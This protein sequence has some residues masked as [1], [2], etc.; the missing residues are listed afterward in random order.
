[1]VTIPNAATIALL[2][3]QRLAEATAAAAAVV[4]A[5]EPRFVQVVRKDALASLLQR[6]QTLRVK[7]RRARDNASL[8]LSLQG[9]CERILAAA[10]DENGFLDLTDFSFAT[11]FREGLAALWDDGPLV[12]EGLLS[13]DLALTEA[14]ATAVFALGGGKLVE[15]L[16]AEEILEFWEWQDA[17]SAADAAATA[18]ATVAVA[19]ISDL[20]NRQARAEALRDEVRAGLVAS[21]PALLAMSEE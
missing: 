15:P 19:A 16:T 14:E 18:M 7:L 6:E 1:M 4:L 20:Q 5:T 12:G 11:Q 8:P 9:G 3:E 10:G 21:L 2:G 13:A 17:V